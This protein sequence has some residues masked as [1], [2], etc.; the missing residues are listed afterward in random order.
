MEKEELELPKGW[1]EGNT[2]GLNFSPLVWGKNPESQTAVRDL[3]NHILKETDMTIALTPH[4]MENGNND[5]E[6]FI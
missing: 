5:Y 1:Q 3:I 2:V 4:V 6:V